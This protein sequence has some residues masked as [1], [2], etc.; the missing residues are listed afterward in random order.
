M[1]WSGPFTIGALLERCLESDRPW[2]PESPGVYVVT[3]RYWEGEPDREAEIL[4]VGGITGKS[5][6]FVTRIGDLIA[7]MY[8]FFGEDTGHHSG[9]QKLHR[10]C[11]TKQV[12]PSSL[13]VAWK[14]DFP[15]ARCAEY[16][17]WEQLKPQLNAISPPRCKVHGG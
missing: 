17:V 12:H 6:R 16:E 5:N 3:R 11:V 4:Y 13:F 14:T 9:G 2:P 15:C 8:G 10:W 7:D 1:P